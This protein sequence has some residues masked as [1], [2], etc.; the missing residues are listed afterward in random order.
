MIEHGF[1]AT[2]S[3]RRSFVFPL[4][5]LSEDGERFLKRLE[6]SDVAY[7][8]ILLPADPADVAQRFLEEI[9]AETFEGRLPGYGRSKHSDLYPNIVVADDAHAFANGARPHPNCYR[10][11][12]LSPPFPLSLA[13]DQ[14]CLAYLAHHDHPTVARR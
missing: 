13:G 7:D 12:K 8:R 2:S 6:A 9:Q 14:T 11:F 1:Y 4:F 5:K 3:N 10:S